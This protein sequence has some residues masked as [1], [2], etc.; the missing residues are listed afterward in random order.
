VSA[1]PDLAAASGTTRRSAIHRIVTLALAQRGLVIAATVVA[2]GAGVWS[3][4]RLPIDAYPDLSSPTVEI[5]TQWPGRAAE[6]VERP[7]PCRSR[8][9]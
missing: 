1:D 9:R 3:F 5:T 4:S 2:A 6:E 7:S 8:P